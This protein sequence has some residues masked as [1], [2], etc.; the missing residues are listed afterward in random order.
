VSPPERDGALTEVRATARVSPTCDHS[1]GRAR[2]EALAFNLSAMAAGVL[3][4]TPRALAA[5]AALGHAVVW[6]LV[7]AA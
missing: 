5:A 6:D 2:A 3:P 1:T 4:S 7:V